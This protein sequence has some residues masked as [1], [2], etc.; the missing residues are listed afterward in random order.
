[1]GVLLGEKRF[2]GSIG[3]SCVP[4]VDFPR[5]MERKEEIVVKMRNGVEAACK[6]RNVTVVRAQG[7]ELALTGRVDLAETAI[8]A[9]L[10]L[11]G[12]ELAGAP[13]GTRPE[14]GIVLKGP[15][16]A[17][18]RTLDVTAFASWLALRAVEQQDQNREAREQKRKNFERRE[19]ERRHRAARSRF[20]RPSYRRPRKPVSRRQ[21]TTYREGVPSLDVRD[22]NDSGDQPVVLE[23]RIA[24][25]ERLPDIN[26]TNARI[27]EI[28]AQ[29]T[30]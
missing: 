13:A 17:P 19:A 7:A 25:G 15:I 18:R 2:I 30:A 24:K 8:D 3:G 4:E 11:S 5:M 10:T 16:E 29:Q 20:P 1:M 23:S 9:R 26:G 21:M 22:A 6:R 28:L 12:P 27:A 14:I